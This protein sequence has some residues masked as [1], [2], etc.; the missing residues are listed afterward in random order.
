MPGRDPGHGD[1]PARY[2]ESSV[3]RVRRHKPRRIQIGEFEPADPR[4]ETRRQRHRE[5][6][7]DIAA[8]HEAEAGRT[9]RRRRGP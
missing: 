3:K 8:N 5:H 7:L 1:H 6:T 2:G 4:R 9:G